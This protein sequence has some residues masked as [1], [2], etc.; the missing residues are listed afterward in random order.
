M[1][2]LAKLATIKDGF[3]HID[4]T[5]ERTS[6]RGTSYKY[7]H[8]AQASRPA[9][10]GTPVGLLRRA[11]CVCLLSAGSRSSSVKPARTQHAAASTLL[12]EI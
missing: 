7:R 2:K 5:N 4:S 3:M 12:R 8:T 1:T 11:T 6:N 10:A 9:S